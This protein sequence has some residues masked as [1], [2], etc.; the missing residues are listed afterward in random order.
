MRRYFPSLYGNENT[1]NRLGLAI[2]SERIAHAFL[3]D[4]AEGAGKLTLALSISAALLCE[5]REDKSSPLPCCACNNCKRVL[6]RIHPDVRILEKQADKAT[7]GVREIR[8]FREDMYLSPTEAD[9]KI[10]IIRDAEKMTPEA[11]NALL[12]VLEEP[13]SNT[14]IF[15]LA[16]GSDRILTTI[17]SRSQYIVCSRFTPDELRDYLMKSGKINDSVLNGDSERL[18][19]LLL[20]SDGRIGRALSLIDSGELDETE[21]RRKDCISLLNAAAIGSSSSEIL[22]AVNALPDKRA[23]LVP[24]FEEMQNAVRDVIAVKETKFPPLLFFTSTQQARDYASRIGISR[25]QKLFD[26]FTNAHEEC[27]KNANVPSLLAT[28]AARIKGM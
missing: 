10:Y 1:K 18:N 28:L 14:K 7:L 19:A 4:G 6:S 21:Q 23:E 26:L 15:L 9:Y 16:S 17:K 5:R 27:L 11:Q 2:E 3:I 25:A 8:E 12:I 13:P 22:L 24:L 20:S